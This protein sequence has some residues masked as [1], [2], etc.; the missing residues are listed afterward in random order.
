MTIGFLY[1]SLTV[2]RVGPPP[3]KGYMQTV[4]SYMLQHGSMLGLFMSIG[5]IIRSDSTHSLTSNRIHRIPI[6]I[7]HNK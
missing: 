1:G 2:L 4:G 5:S 6:H 7:Q 3:G